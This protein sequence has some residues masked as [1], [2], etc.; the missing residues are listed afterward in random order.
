MARNTQPT[1]P[2]APPAPPP[3]AVKT[4]HSSVVYGIDRRGNL[5]VVISETATP[6]QVADDVR[7][8][9]GL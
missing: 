4:V 1:E 7:T 2:P 5:Q 8:L 9:A 3:P 6:Q